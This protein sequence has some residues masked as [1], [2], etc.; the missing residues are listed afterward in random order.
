MS[1]SHAAGRGVVLAAVVFL[2]LSACAGAPVQEMSNAR[3]AI[4]AARSAGAEERAPEQFTQ[5][6][7]LMAQAE[8][9][10]QKNDYKSARAQAV[11]ARS[12]ALQA[13]RTAAPEGRKADDR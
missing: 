13:L 9:S 1:R 12:R 2:G 3:Q 6:T 7:A 11:Q 4:A 5:A 8:D 10:L